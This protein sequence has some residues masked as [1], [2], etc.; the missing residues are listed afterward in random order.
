MVVAENTTYYFLMIILTPLLGLLIN[1]L[2]FKKNPSLGS[3]I[4]SLGIWIGFINT[5]G[6]WFIGLPFYEK[7]ESAGFIANE[8]SWLMAT[9]ILFI[10]GVVHHFSLRYMAGDRNYRR[11]FLFLG[12]I[13]ISTLLLAASDNIVIL[14]LFWSLSNLLLV[15][16]MMHKFEW[17]AAK[18]SGVLAIKT[19][20]LGLVFLSIGTGL[21]AYESGTL[22]LHLIMEKSE[23][24]T[25]SI[26][27]TTLFFIILAAFSQSGGWP[28]HS[29]LISS[30]NSPTP[31]SAFMHAGL[32][33]GGGLLIARFAPIFFQ[34]S[35][36]A[37]V[38][39]IL[40]LITLILGGIWKLIQSDIKRMLACSTMTQM[41]FMMMQCGLGLFPAALAHLFWHGLFKAFL[42]LRSGSTIAEDRFQ[43][44]E[45]ESTVPA[46]ILSSL[47]GLL[48]AFGF[49]IGSGLSFTLIDT[50]AV[51]IFFCW[52]ASTQLA[53]TLLQKKQS[54]FFV[55]ITSVF[56]LS[57]GLIYGLTVYLIE[58]AVAPLQISQ[59]QML[60]SIHITAVALIFFIWIGLNLKPLTN[61]E[62]SLWWRRFYVK[63]L[64]ASQP[65]PKAIT[66]IRSGYKF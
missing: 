23:S 8:I 28:F 36:L 35:L 56:S 48:G 22:S 25:A 49:I 55:L 7:N 64:N 33:N 62:G 21:L 10:S 16:L 30:L 24:L 58:S 51:L 43:N 57:T 61:H 18:N 31:V 12:L 52:M 42:F 38:L 32:V 34:E 59:P 27:M 5:L 14:I 65:D 3:R 44:E 63:M 39:F 6:A 29:W 46:F 11:Y 9:L 1:L 15:L 17:E 50:T 54:L 4:A 26:R 47:C 53:H 13:T 66:S 60:S 40:A 45:K 37:N 41:G 20:A 2:F 19:F